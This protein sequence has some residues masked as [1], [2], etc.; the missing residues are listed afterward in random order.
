MNSSLKNS[1]HITLAFYK[2][3]ANLIHKIIRWWTKSEYSHVELILP[4]D[5]TWISISPFFTSKV[6]PRI[7]TKLP[8]PEDWKMV[9]LPLSHR[10]PVRQYQIEQLYKFVERTQG[11]KYDW[12][13]MILSQFGPFIVKNKNKWYCSEWIAHALQYSRII[14]WDD[15]NTYSTPDMSPGKLYKIICDYKPIYK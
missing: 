14:L 13:G 2:G 11:S 7:V 9:R 15:I 12:T 6:T 1:D 5:Y 8:N 3:H 10:E 4:D